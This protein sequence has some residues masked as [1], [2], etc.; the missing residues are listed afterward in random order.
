MFMW[1]SSTLYPNPSTHKPTCSASN[2]P[3]TTQNLCAYE[4][5]DLLTLFASDSRFLCYACPLVGEQ[6]SSAVQHC[7]IRWAAT[8]CS[9]GLSCD[10]HSTIKGGKEYK[11]TRLRQVAQ[12]LQPEAMDNWQR[13]SCSGSPNNELTENKMT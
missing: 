9:E 13:S 12:P 6:I 3:S 2:K 1:C 11:T 7:S 5:V 10:H 4:S 8:S